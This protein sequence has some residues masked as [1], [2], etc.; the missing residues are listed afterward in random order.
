MCIRDRYAPGVQINS[1]W[2]G[3]T[4]HVTSGT[5]MSAPFV[6]GRVAQLM[7]ENASLTVVE[8]KKQLLLQARWLELNYF[9]KEKDE[10]LEAPRGAPD[11]QFRGRILLRD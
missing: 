2:V 5:S 4:Y 11:R 6:A 9:E 8:A 10:E 7:S 1:T 3:S